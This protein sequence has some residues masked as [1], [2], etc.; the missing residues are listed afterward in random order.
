MPHAYHIIENPQYV[1]W[2]FGLRIQ[3]KLRIDRRNSLYRM[4]QSE[5]ESNA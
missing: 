3:I 2:L 1:L 4:I 5:K